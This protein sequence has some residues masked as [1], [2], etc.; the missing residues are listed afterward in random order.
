MPVIGAFAKGFLD[1]LGMQNFGEAPRE[2][3]YTVA[4]IVDLSELYLLSKQGAFFGGTAGNMVANFNA[5]PGAAPF[6][7]GFVVPLGEVWRLHAANVI[8]VPAAGASGIFAP[9]IQVD[10][11]NLLLSSSRSYVAS[12]RAAQQME[13]SPMWLNA[14]SQIGVWAQDVVGNTPASLNFLVSRLRA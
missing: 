7:A 8:V 13:A 14:G 12:T 2:L 4:P 11:A 5:C 6:A 3:A 9:A 1:L 10:G